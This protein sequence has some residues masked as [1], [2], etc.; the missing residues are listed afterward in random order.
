MDIDRPTAVET[1]KYLFLFA[2]R[3][4]DLGEESPRR[5]GQVIIGCEPPADAVA[6]RDNFCIVHEYKMPLQNG[7]RIETK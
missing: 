5:L 7:S 2:D 4:F 3:L 1:T 6:Y